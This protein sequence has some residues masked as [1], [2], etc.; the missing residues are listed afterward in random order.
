MNEEPLAPC[1]CAIDCFPPTTSIVECA[2]HGLPQ[3]LEET[4]FPGASPKGAVLMVKPKTKEVIAIAPVYGP[5]QATRARQR[6]EE[7]GLTFAEIVTIY[8]PVDLDRVV[9]E[10]DL[11][12]ASEL[13]HKPGC[14]FAP[15]QH[16]GDCYVESHLSGE[17]TVD[18]II[19]GHTCRNAR[20]A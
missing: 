7:L 5:E 9:T 3:N 8:S 17:G 12:P 15:K 19:E 10:D 6:G 1:S 16:P 20:L 2:E 18:C 13:T 4:D 14:I 11:K